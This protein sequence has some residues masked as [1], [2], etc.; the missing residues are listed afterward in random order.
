[1]RGRCVVVFLFVVVFFDCKNWFKQ[2]LWWT[3]LVLGFYRWILLNHC[4]LD[5]ES[6]FTSD[7]V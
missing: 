3:I 4:F 2:V 6:L 5:V 7:Y 1:M